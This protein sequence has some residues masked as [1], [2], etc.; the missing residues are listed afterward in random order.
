MWLYRDNIVLKDFL[1]FLFTQ[2][3]IFQFWTPDSL[4]GF[5]CGTPNGSLWTI[6]AIIQ[7]YLVAWFVTNIFQGR[8]L[9]FWLL[10]FVISFGFSAFGAFLKG[11]VPVL[12]AKLYGQT[13]FMHFWMFLT[14][15]FISEFKSPILNILKKYW[16]AFVGVSLVFYWLHVDLPLLNYPFIKS[17]FASVG[18]IGF[19]YRFPRLEFKTDISYSVYIYHMIFVNVFIDF[20]F[21]ENKVLMIYIILLTFVS[22]YISTQTLGRF[23]LS[24][25][26]RHTTVQ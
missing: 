2:S 12:L 8:S 16:Y 19:A 22:S 6:C 26:K 13:L 9:R 25:K 17:V 23:G 3:T 5:G 21:L 15:A 18:L 11:N 20:G 14:G 10:A 7:Y 4:R 1:L 24:M